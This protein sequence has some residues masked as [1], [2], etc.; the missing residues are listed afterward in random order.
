MMN[1]TVSVRIS[2]LDDFIIKLL[3]NHFGNKI[4]SISRKKFQLF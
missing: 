1:L 4:D 3:F 2:D